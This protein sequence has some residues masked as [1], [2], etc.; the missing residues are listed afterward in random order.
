VTTQIGD[1]YAHAVLDGG[2]HV[3]LLFGRPNPDVARELVAILDAQDFIAPRTSLFDAS[4]IEAI[5]TESFAIVTE[6][7][8][9]RRADLSKCVQK[10]A[11]V[12]PRGMPGAIVTGYRAVFDFSYPV[13]FFAERA[14]ALAF[15]GRPDALAAVDDIAAS[16]A[17]PMLVRLRNLLSATLSVVLPD[18]ARQLGVSERSLQRY[19]Q[20]EGTSFVD[21]VQS[22][23][24]A[25]AKKLLAETDRK[26]TTIATDVGCAS[27][28]SF[29]TMFRR[30]TG[31][32]PSEFRAR[33]RTS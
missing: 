25:S 27:L 1:G 32:T 2:L 3:T 24:I 16:A 17:R 8:N 30:I 18:A 23:R 19:L 12:T 9:R 13:E 22:A 26:L 20:T 10:Q 21:E 11:I 5:E 14:L 33:S 31:E 4:G 15:L 6:H 28:Q 7:Q 29:S